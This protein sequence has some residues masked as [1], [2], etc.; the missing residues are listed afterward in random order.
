MSNASA[1]AGSRATVVRARPIDPLL[2]I[3]FGGAALGTLPRVRTAAARVRELRDTGRRIVVVVSARGNTT[4]RLLRDVGGMLGSREAC[5]R[6]VDRALATGEALASALLASALLAVGVPAASVC[7]TNAVLIADGPYGGGTLRE[8][9]A[10]RIEE[11]LARGDVPVVP[12]FQGVRDDGELVTLGRGSSDV[13]AVF[14]AA[15]LG[16]RECHLVKDVDGV[17][18]HDPLV[19][20]GAL[21]FDD[22]SFDDLVTLTA[23]GA[24]VVHSEAALRAKSAAVPLRVYRHDAPVTRPRG[25]RVGEE[26]SR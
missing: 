7:A 10:G 20:P 9:R 12:G 2:V 5:G 14:L 23:G 11:L 4:D 22:L 3:K 6:E 24:Q 17:Y 13:T 15:A 26:A 18:A 8:L 16:A 21:H 25:T 1:V 19:V